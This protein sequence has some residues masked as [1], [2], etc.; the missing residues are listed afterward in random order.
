MS[1]GLVNEDFNH[2]GPSCVD[3]FL[4][5]VALISA[6]VTFSWTLSLHGVTKC[7]AMTNPREPNQEELNC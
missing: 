7:I 2:T 4:D 5:N 3:F 1:P 6:L